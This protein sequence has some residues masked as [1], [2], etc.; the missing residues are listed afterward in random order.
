MKNITKLKCDLVELKSLANNLAKNAKAGNIYLL[1]GDLGVGKTT[2]TRLLIEA[3][4]YRFKIKKPKNI[5]SPSFPI[6][7]NYSLFNYE[8][9]HY[10]L[11]RI[12]NLQELHEIGFFEN[13][14]KNITIVEWPD[15]IINHNELNKNYFINFEFIDE[16]ERF[17]TIQNNNT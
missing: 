17:V 10:D 16:N 8:I 1:D 5:R 4:Y 15:I 14:K 11:Y 12:S 13:L 6:M 2:F 3:I 7:I 9:N